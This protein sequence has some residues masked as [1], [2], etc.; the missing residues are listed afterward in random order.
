VCVISVLGQATRAHR[1]STSLYSQRLLRRYR[2]RVEHLEQGDGMEGASRATNQ[3]TSHRSS[4]LQ[5]KRLDCRKELLF[6]HSWVSCVFGSSRGEVAEG[7]R[8]AAKQNHG[9]T[10]GSTQ[11]KHN[12]TQLPATKLHAVPASSARKTCAR[13]GG[14]GFR[15]RSE[16]F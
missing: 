14:P 1:S 12:F 5:H 3:M 7:G 4:R 6:V 15:P 16:Q 10:Q 11:E 8:N 2:R 9:A 13:A